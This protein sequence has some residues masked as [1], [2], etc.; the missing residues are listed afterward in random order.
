MRSADRRVITQ[1]VIRFASLVPVLGL[2]SLAAGCDS[3]TVAPGGSTDGGSIDP[4]PTMRRD[5]GPDT[6]QP[7]PPP[8]DAGPPQVDSGCPAPARLTPADVPP[9]YLPAEVVRFDHAADGDTATFGFP[10]SGEHIVRFLYVNT[11]ESHGA[12]TT[13]FGTATGEIVMARFADATEVVVAPREDTGVPGTPDLDPYDRWLGL[14]FVDGE[15]FQTWLLR[16]GLSAY[17]TQFGCAPEPYHSTFLNAEAEARANER[18]IW[19]P[20]HPTDYRAVL[21]TWNR[22][23]CRPGYDAPYCR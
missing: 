23:G 9:G 19:A 21:A 7:P 5:A 8:L 4:D 15:L 6:G 17:Y 2:L 12:E 22:T 13:A 16:E 11:E 3:R 18:G 20:G 1:V 10:S 14:V